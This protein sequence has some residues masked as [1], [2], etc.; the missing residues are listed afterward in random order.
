[1]RIKYITPAILWALVI[2]WL[3]AIPGQDLP[4]WNLFTFDKAGHAVIFLILTLL[5]IFGFQKQKA[6]ISFRHYFIILSL[7]ISIIYGGA[8]ELMQQ[9]WFENRTADIM[10]FTAN[11]A[12]SVLALPFYFLFLKKYL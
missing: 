9:F 6:G 10:D 1:M 12:G 3:C 8:T 5:L 7:I 11:A 2:L 4:D